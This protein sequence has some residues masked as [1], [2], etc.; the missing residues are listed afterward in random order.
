MFAAMN[1]E[2][3]ALLAEISEQIHHGPNEELFRAG[4]P[5]Q[6]LSILLAGFVAETHI[7]L[8]REVVIDVIAPVA[9][10]AFSAALAGKTSPTGARTV[11][12]A[13]LIVIAAPELRAMIHAEPRTRNALLGPC[14]R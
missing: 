10:I 6:V 12:A 13:R 8:G 9:P 11:T 7:D 5:L 2:H 4:E 3:L 1:G 14:I